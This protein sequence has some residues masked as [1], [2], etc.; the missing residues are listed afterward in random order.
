MK[1]QLKTLLRAMLIFMVG[2]MLST[3]LSSCAAN[4]CDCPEFG[5]HRLKH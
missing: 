4:K 1:N 5:G 3:S 2:I